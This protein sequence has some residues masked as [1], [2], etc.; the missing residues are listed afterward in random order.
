MT[1]SSFIDILR[2]RAL[3]EPERLAFSFWQDGEIELDRLTY[4]SL[5]RQAR[6]IAAQ[7]QSLELEGKTALLLYPPGL[8]FVSAFFGCLYAG[9]VAVPAYPPR[10]DRFIDRLVN[11]ATDAGVETVLTTTETQAKLE[12]R[13]AQVPQ[14]QLAWLTTDNIA[15]ELEQHWQQSAIANDTLAFLQYTSGST[16][17]PKGVMVTHGNLL[18]NSEQIYRCFGHTP[19]SQGVVWLPPYHDMGL[20]GGVLQPVYG[21][22]PVTL[23]SPVAFLQKPIRWLEA[24]SKAQATTSGGPNFAYELCIS[25]TTPEQR[26]N[27]DLSSWEVAFNGA[28]PIRAET[29]E[30]FSEAFAPYG[31]R[32]EAFYPCYG[33]AEATLIISGGLKSAAPVVCQVDSKAIEQNRVV[34]PESNNLKTFVGLG[35]T[36]LDQQVVIVDPETLTECSP[37]Q[38]GEI[39]VAGASIAQGYWNQPEISQQTFQAYLADTQQGPFFRTGD[40]GFLQDG[41]LFITGRLKDLIIIR[42]QNHYPQDIELTVEQSHSA[43]RL[44]CSA[45]FTVEVVGIERLAIALEV[46]RSYL[47]RLDVEAVASAIRQAVSEAHE[48]QVYAVALLKTGTIPKTSSGKIQRYAC[49][50][51]F[52]AGTLEVV[53]DWQEPLPS[54]LDLQPLSA[55]APLVWPQTSESASITQ[56][57]IQAWLVCRLSQELNIAAQEIDTQEAFAYYGLDSSAAIGITGELIDWLGWEVEPTLFWEYP[58]IEELAVYLANSSSQLS[59]AA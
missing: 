7:L 44:G 23:M 37:T 45:A 31:F 34:A 4:Q 25:K 20:I 41:E 56:E 17:M 18:H 9:V 53:G 55:S 39:W 8:E 3:N 46:E 15:S 24:I 22:F 11:I 40:L 19:N 12:R 5:D 43:L 21:G 35:Q 33:M 27:L 42:G 32:R 50:N 29:L 49:R 58:N 47:R 28:E 48:L 6:A 13:L 54:Q 57:Q 1:H 16:A 26:A 36:W 51:S 38:V 30:R 52:L 10:R 2:S 59:S 14:L